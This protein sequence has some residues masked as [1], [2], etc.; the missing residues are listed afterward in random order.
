[1]PATSPSVTFLMFGFFHDLLHSQ[2]Q[3][4]DAQV[5]CVSKLMRGRNHCPDSTSLAA[6]EMGN[7]TLPTLAD[8]GCPGGDGGMLGSVDMFARAGEDIGALNCS[9]RA[10]QMLCGVGTKDVPVRSRAAINGDSDGSNRHGGGHHHSLHECFCLA[11]RQ[12][13]ALVATHY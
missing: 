13:S 11:K 7:A 6:T 1:M 10:A 4:D 12:C 5:A 2:K 3:M 8:V 9:G